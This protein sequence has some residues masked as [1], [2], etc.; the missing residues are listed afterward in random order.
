MRSILLDRDFLLLSSL[1]NLL[2]PLNIASKVSEVLLTFG[3]NLFFP[4][5]LQIGSFLLTYIL[6]EQGF[7]VISILPL[8]LPI[9]FYFRYC[10]FQT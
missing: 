9:A 10:A 7:P 6:G 1:N 3:K 2:R 8:H 4:S 5:V